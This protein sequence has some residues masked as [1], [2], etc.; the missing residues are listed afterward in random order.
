[1][2][3]KMPERLPFLEDALQGLAFWVGYRR[4]YFRDYPL[5][6]AAL[7]AETCNLIQSKI[8]DAQVLRPEVLYRR[9]A[10]TSMK[11]ELRDLWRAD[12]AILD[13]AYPNP[14]QDNVWDAV[15]F[16]FEVKR[17]SSPKAEIDQDLRRLFHFKEVCRSGARAFL[18]VVSEAKLPKRFV[19][20][21]KGKSKLHGHPIPGTTGVYHVRR[22][23]KA[24]SS[25]DRKETANF[26]CIC[27]VFSQPP[28]KVLPEV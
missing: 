20:P 18:I 11:D 22:T 19:D 26:A 14:Y 21:K 17:G 8:T 9:L 1:M 13:A 16:I 23:V 24:A 15:H 4:S 3:Y 12:L 2:G 7:I 5:A 10:D 25:F 27:E 28:K 6:E